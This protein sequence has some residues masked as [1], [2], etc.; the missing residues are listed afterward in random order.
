MKPNLFILGAARC[1]TSSLH[2]IL[3]QHPDIHANREKEPTFFVGQG[4]IVTNPVEYLKLFD[5]PKRYRLDSSV[6][7]LVCPETAPV[8]RELFPDARFIVSL[9]EP[10]ARAYALY[11]HM[12]YI[13]LEPISSFADALEADAYRQTSRDF[14]CTCHWPVPNYLYCR[15]TIFD[16]HLARYFSLFD[17]EQFH[18]LTLAELANNPINT[19]KRILRFLDLDPTPAPHFNF[20]INARWENSYEPYDARSDQI[21]STQFAGVTQRTEELVGQSLDWT[22]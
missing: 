11:R 14:L 22:I 21:M 15:S 10:K 2:T 5:S 13:K 6:S 4:Q 9:R 1:G 17:R 18:V 20:S 3:G 12:R 19:T 8:L 16:E 7:Y